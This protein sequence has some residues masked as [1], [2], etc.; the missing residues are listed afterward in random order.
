MRSYN[1]NDVFICGG[2]Y[3]ELVRS[4]QRGKNNGSFIAVKLVELAGFVVVVN[5]VEMA[6]FVIVVN[7]RK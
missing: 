1:E 3:S 2:Q 7:W 6:G 5:E 4:G